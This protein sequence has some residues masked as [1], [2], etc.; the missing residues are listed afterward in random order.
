MTKIPNTMRA[1]VI[2][3]YGGTEAMRYG[4]MAVPQPG[5]GDLLVR[6]EVASVNPV[7]WKVRSG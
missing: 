7:D 2:N 3:G 5:R 4:S 6:I 1:W